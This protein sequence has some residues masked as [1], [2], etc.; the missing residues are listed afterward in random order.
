MEGIEAVAIG[1]VQLFQLLQQ[2]QAPG[3]VEAKHLANHIGTVDTIL[4]PD[5]G[6]GEVA[7]AF[8]KA[9]HIAVGPALPFQGTDLL[10]D[11]LKA[12]QYIPGF[13]AVMLRNALGQVHGHD[14]FH[15][16][17]VLWHF[18][19]AGPL[20]ADIVQQQQAHLIAG[21][22]LIVSHG[23]LHRNAHPVTIRV[24]GKKQIRVVFLCVFHAQSHGF[25]D[26]RVGIGAGGEMAIRP[27]LLRYHGN[28]GVAHFLQS[29]GHGLQAAAI[30]GG[31]DNGHIPVNFISKE[32]RL[33]LYRLYKG[34]IHLG[35]H[36]FDGAGPQRRLKI[37]PGNI[38][39]NIQLLNFSQDLPGGGGGDLAAVRAVD[40]VAVVF[41]RVVGGSDH[42]TGGGL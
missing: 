9:E 10:A 39:K 22:E 28:I 6:T 41:G 16:D 11:E 35:F 30:E 34:G 12:R 17:R 8:F 14:G 13:Q 1:F 4:I 36:I 31:I 38:L 26:F 19:V 5:I 20:G 33:P 27:G 7:V 37:H 24:C 23:I 2:A 42:H 15:Q 18:P 32:H 29:P 21:Q 25:P 3:G 40:L